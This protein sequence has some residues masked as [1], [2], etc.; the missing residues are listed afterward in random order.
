MYVV[1]SC[2]CDTLGYKMLYTSLFSNLKHKPINRSLTIVSGLPFKY[3]DWCDLIFWLRYTA[4]ETWRRAR[5]LEER[6]VNF[7]ESE[8]L[9][10]K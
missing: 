6:V 9:I 10:E 1:S 3:T 8:N 5:A 2:F 4:Y 7:E